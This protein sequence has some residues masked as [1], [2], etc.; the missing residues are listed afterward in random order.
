MLKLFGSLRRQVLLVLVLATAPLAALAVYLAVDDGRRDAAEAQAEARATVHLVKQDLDRLLESSSDL[1]IGLSRNPLLSRPAECHALLES[2]HPSFP[3]FAN[4]GVV[5]RDGRIDCIA[6]NPSNLQAIR[7]DAAREALLA[8]LSGGSRFVVGD[9]TY[10]DVVRRPML[11]L[12]AAIGEEEG[13]AE[14]FFEASVDLRWVDGQVNAMRLP[15]KAILL[16]MDR[17]GTLVA[18][19]PPSS[20]WRVGAPAP[21]YEQTL[22]GLNEFDGEVRGEGGIKRLYSVARAGPEGGLLVVMK[23][24]SE[25]IYRPSRRRLAVHLSGL[26]GVALLVLALTWLGSDRYFATPLLVLI[27]EANRLATGDL[28]ARSGLAYDSE[29]GGLARSLDEMADALQRE[30]AKSLATIGQ[31][32][33]MVRKLRALAA[34][35]QSV[36]EEERTHIAREIHDELGQQLTAM[37]FDLFHL[38]KRLRE[39]A[40]PDPLLDSVAGL[41]SMVDSTI[42][43]VR[44]IATELRPL[45]LD[46]FG[47]I[48]AI[49]WLADD[50]EK[51]T[52]I[53]CIYEGPE[54]LQTGRD[55]A[56]TLFRI[57]QESLTNIARHSHATEARIRLTAE[58]EWIALEVSDNGCG[59]AA[60]TREAAQSFGLLGM[61]ER[62][63][64]AGG[65]LEIRSETGRGTVVVA[66]IPLDAGKEAHA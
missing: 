43:S 39:S 27:R 50:F 31:N 3:Q 29:I 51:R 55:L 24:R 58:S 54:E 52:D 47:L 63:T 65:T 11:P 22:A 49:E 19:N 61:R 6:S 59:I 8:Q 18:R 38:R 23:I 60:G 5:E 46:T 1:L 44:R 34:R 66:R 26:G 40:S 13:A 16:V 56:T 33:E 7:N 64:M 32:E 10:G 57:C 42:G 36:R 48:A 4:M 14:R 30:K 62:A 35:L 15:D 28:S 2:L 12:V 21:A 17:R 41:T 45:V 25:E 53:R 37:R 20:E 9:V